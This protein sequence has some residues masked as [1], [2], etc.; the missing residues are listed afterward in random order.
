VPS[1]KLSRRKFSKQRGNV[2][3]PV[4]V[5]SRARS[6]SILALTICGLLATACDR[7]DHPGRIGSR[8]SQ[9]TVSDGVQTVDIA[10]LRGHIVILNFWATWCVPCIE[11]VPTLVELQHRMPQVTVVA[12]SG[13]EDASAYRQ[14]LLDNRVDFVTVRDPSNRIPRQYGTI[15]IPESYVIDRKGIL[16]RKFVSAQNWTSPEILEYLSKL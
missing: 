7:G 2:R 11:E 13:D 15:K 1:L 10:K 9:F 8:A 6:L 12:I 16:R 4:A 3:A 5:R 14:F